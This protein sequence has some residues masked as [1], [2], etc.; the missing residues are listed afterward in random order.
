MGSADLHAMALICGG[1]VD[2]ATISKGLDDTPVPVS[3][4][5]SMPNRPLFQS[6]QMLPEDTN[7]PFPEGFH[8]A[9][10]TNFWRR[11]IIRIPLNDTLYY[12]TLQLGTST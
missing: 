3:F 7:S 4:E 6:P 10:S 2:L 9:P 1:V 12:R 8:N 5:D 11:W